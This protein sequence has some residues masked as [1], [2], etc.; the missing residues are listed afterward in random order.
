MINLYILDL[1]IMISL[2][3]WLVRAYNFAQDYRIIK[4]KIKLQVVRICS[5][6]L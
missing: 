2:K 4:K 6:G 5:Y 3:R 1:D